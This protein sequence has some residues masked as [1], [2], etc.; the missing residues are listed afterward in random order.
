MFKLYRQLDCA[1]EETVPCYLE[2]TQQATL[3]RKFHEEKFILV[4][5][6]L[7]DKP[8]WLGCV[9]QF[10]SKETFPTITKRRALQ[11]KHENNYV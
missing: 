9:K 8:K 10:S 1:L 11:T 3:W 4:N 6:D 7:K 2:K 5:V